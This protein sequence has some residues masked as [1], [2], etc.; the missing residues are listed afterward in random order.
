[1]HISE[2]VLNTPTLVA[3]YAVALPTLAY[4]MRSL[5]T[6]NLLKTAAFSAL[7]LVV[8]FIHIPLGPSS[9]HLLF[10]GILGAVLGR[11]AFVAIFIALFIQGL[12]FGFGGIYVLGV[13][14]SIM[15][16][17]ALFTSFIYNLKLD[18]RFFTPSVRY[19]LAGFLG[20]LLGTIFLLLVMWA[21][22][23]LGAGVTVFI[24]NIPLMIVEGFISLVVLKYLLRIG[25]L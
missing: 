4:T 17:A 15:G 8:S 14:S 24:G 3:G 20:V 13:N 19:F 7:F 23:L 2:G 18:C 25:K 9:I 16:L 21:N 1:M 11:A 5:N 22:G 6:A 12:M 10:I